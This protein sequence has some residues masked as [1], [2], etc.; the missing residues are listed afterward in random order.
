MPKQI[1]G[2]YKVV[3][4]TEGELEEIRNENRRKLDA[5]LSNP[6]Y[7]QELGKKYYGDRWFAI[8]EDGHW[9]K[10]EH[11]KI[12]N[13]YGAQHKPYLDRTLIQYDLDGNE[14]GEWESAK[15]WA[16]SEGKTYSAAQHVAKSALG[17]HMGGRDTAYGYRWRFKKEDDE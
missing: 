6:N 9:M 2:R 8:F 3:Q 13:K 17:V 11:R 5:I 14:V 15:I 1:R 16:D 7:M 4:L 12:V 10:T